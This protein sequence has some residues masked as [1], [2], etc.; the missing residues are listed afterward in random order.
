M[1]TALWSGQVFV[2]LFAA[3]INIIWSYCFRWTNRLERFILCTKVFG[4]TTTGCPWHFV[5]SFFFL[6]TCRK[7]FVKFVVIKVFKKHLLPATSVN[8]LMCTSKFSLSL[9]L[10]LVLAWKGSQASWKPWLF[11]PYFL[12]CPNLFWLTCHF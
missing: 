12:H 6:W 1:H 2:F 8:V 7:K 5:F 4:L 11:D 9:S 10:F 3:K